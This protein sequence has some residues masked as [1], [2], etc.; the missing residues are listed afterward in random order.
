MPLRELPGRVLAGAVTVA[1]GGAQGQE[2]PSASLGAG[3]GNAFERLMG[4]SLDV[5]I[6]AAIASLR[7]DLFLQNVV[8]FALLMLAGIAWTLFAFLV[9]A[10][11]MISRDWFEQSITEYGTSTGVTA[12]GLMLLRIVDPQN[13]TTGAQAFGAR[14]MVISPIF[15]GGLLTATVPLLLL[16]FGPRLVL[17]GITAL[18]L[19]L[20]FWPGH[21]PRSGS[22]QKLGRA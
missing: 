7:L 20:Y 16:G 6:V 8:P 3:L 15:G 9:L 5:L 14:A 2:S 19:V 21:R 10:P 12:I 1:C 4:L 11:R 17:A 22:A 13:R 18:A